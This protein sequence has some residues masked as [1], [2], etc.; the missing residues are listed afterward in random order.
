VVLVKKIELN[1]INTTPSARIL[2]A[3]LH[4]LG[5]ASTPPHLRRGT[6]PSTCDLF[7]PVTKAIS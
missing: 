4:F 6:L 3:L 2:V 1:L 7:T 5:R